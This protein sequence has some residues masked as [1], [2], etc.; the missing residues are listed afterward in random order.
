MIDVYMKLLNPNVKYIFSNDFI[1]YLGVS[2]KP[3]SVNE[4]KTLIS[5]K[6][7]KG[8]K[9]K[10]VSWEDKQIFKLNDDKK[11]ILKIDQV[12]KYVMSKLII[13]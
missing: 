4:I 10:N 12:I 7:F 11:D 1:D 2:P 3:Y 8:A 6:I 5:D 13:G 9:T